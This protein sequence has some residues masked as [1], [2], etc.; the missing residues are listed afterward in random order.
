MTIQNVQFASLD[1]NRHL[2][3]QFARKSK[4][5]IVQLT[6][7]RITRNVTNVLKAGSQAK[8]K[9]NANMIFRI[10]VPVAK[11][12]LDPP[13]RFSHIHA[14]LV[15][16]YRQSLYLTLKLSSYAYPLTYQFLTV[17]HS[18]TCQL[19]VFTLA[20]HVTQ[21]TRKSKST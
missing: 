14:L 21:T 9:Q 1:G 2:I 6:I 8:T 13:N 4:S 17:S 18:L 3:E 12:P 16:L 5:N 20:F 10:T 15:T 7:L 19:Q 11:Y